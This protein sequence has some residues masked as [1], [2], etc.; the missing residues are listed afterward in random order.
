VSS[1]YALYMAG[2]G[3]RSWFEFLVVLIT[4]DAGRLTD[5]DGVGDIVSTPT[6]CY[7]ILITIHSY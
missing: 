6:G 2:P 3:V 5:S 7:V 4:G 1:R